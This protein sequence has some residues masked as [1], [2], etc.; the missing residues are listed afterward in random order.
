[1]PVPPPESEAAMVS[2]AGVPHPPCTGEGDIVWY[3]WQKSHPEYFGRTVECLILGIVVAMGTCNS[4]DTAG[5][6]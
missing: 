2:I 3:R 6:S 5:D 1:M 4:N